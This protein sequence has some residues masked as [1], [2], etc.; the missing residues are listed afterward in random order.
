MSESNC[1]PLPPLNQ[2]DIE[3][4]WKYVDKRGPDECWP[5]TGAKS[6]RGYG[7]FEMPTATVRACRVAWY[8]QNGTD[9]YPLMIRH[10]CRLKACSNA[11]HF[12]L[13]NHQNNM[14]DAV[15]DGSMASGDRNASRLYPE[16]LRRGTTHG[17]AKMSDETVALAR[18]LNSEGVSLTAIAAQ[19]GVS[20]STVS[21]AVRGDTWDHIE[22]GKTSEPL[23]RRGALHKGAKVND[24]IVVE[25]R[26]KKAQGR[27][28]QSIANEY[29]LSV[30][31]VFAI[32]TRKTWKH[33]P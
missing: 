5:W 9:P 20:L 14:D 26:L 32:V 12:L 19:F 16:K 22:D 21:R 4:F 13:G 31:A 10:Q 29:G 27:T 33:I 11:K 15:R 2:K 1:K 30:Y 24:V 8:V 18:K 23:H 6:E 3:R 7:V 25:I 17:M 28:Y